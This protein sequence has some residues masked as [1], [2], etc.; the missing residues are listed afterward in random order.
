MQKLARRKIAAHIADQLVA[1]GDVKRLSE[2][3]V[4][5]LVEQGQLAQAELLIRDIEAAL[6]V[7]EVSVVHVT[8]A[9]KL[10]DG[11]RQQ[12]LD[13]VRREEGTKHA[14][15]STETIDEDLIGGIV[16]RTSQSVFDASVRGK[17]RKLNQ[18]ATTE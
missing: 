8:S 1:G 17:L 6:A 10:S 4:A 9:H 7:H 12:A 16:V 2:E 18:L 5:L 13:M 14:V 11:E 3:A 15:V